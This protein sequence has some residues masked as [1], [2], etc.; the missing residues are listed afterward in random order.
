MLGIILATTTHIPRSPDL[1][2]AVGVGGAP[3]DG[4]YRNLEHLL[5]V[6]VLTNLVTWFQELIR[7][8]GA[9]S[10]GGGRDPL[11]L[12]LW[13]APAAVAPIGPLAWEPPY[14][15]KSKKTKQNNN[16]KRTT[17]IKADR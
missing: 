11:V 10:C 17:R 14:A 12:W 9:M 6:M 1:R 13:H 8:G 7:K 2:N 4:N 16:N 3:D 15:L 5:L